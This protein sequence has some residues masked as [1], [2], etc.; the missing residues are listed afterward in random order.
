MVDPDCLQGVLWE[1][2]PEPTFGCGP[3]TQHFGM[4][5][6]ER[7]DG[8]LQVR[9]AEICPEAFVWE[10]TTTSG[11]TAHARVT[12]LGMTA[13]LEAE[14]H[15]SLQCFLQETFTP[16]ASAREAREGR[17][18][19][20]LLVCNDG[21][22]YALSRPLLEFAHTATNDVAASWRRTAVVVDR[23]KCNR[24]DA[25]LEVISLAGPEPERLL[26]DLGKAV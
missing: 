20:T 23:A 9:Q 12:T 26:Y 3:H 8:V 19:A 22:A 5:F 13:A 6:G 11:S 14:L 10:P 18:C 2:L 7:V 21:D 17:L 16:W 15:R 25:A 24:P 4:L 1:D